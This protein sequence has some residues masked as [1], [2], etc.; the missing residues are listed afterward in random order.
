MKIVF[1]KKKSA[2]VHGINMEVFL[3]I[4]LMKERRKSKRKLEK[5]TEH[6]KIGS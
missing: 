5:D 1:I 6:C 4:Y 2:V 3:F